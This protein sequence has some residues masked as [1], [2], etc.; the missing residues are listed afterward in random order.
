[1]IIY[2]DT[3]NVNIVKIYF[4]KNLPPVS[5]SDVTEYCPY[6]YIGPSTHTGDMDA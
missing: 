3:L 4:L 1:M 5:G 6:T 2:F